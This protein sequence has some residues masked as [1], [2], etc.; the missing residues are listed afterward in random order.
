MGIEWDKLDIELLA[1]LIN[2]LISSWESLAWSSSI[3]TFTCL[4]APSE[5]PMKSAKALLRAIKK[6]DIS[7]CCEFTQNTGIARVS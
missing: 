7:H 2:Q 4:S 5:S 6:S 1:N 3:N